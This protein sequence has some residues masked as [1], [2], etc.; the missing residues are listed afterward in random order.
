[1]LNDKKRCQFCAETI[2]AAAVKCRFCGS[3]L[4]DA[5]LATPRAA[6][7]TACNVALVPVQKRRA[8]SVG[9]VLGALAVAAGV[10]T[11]V[12]NLIGG[13]LAILVGVALSSL[14]GKTVVMKCPQC[15]TQGATLS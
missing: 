1:M 8:V 12:F 10:I 15:G 9:G 13:L 11:L 6:C 14:S 3:D 7:C 2:K 5:H 4:T